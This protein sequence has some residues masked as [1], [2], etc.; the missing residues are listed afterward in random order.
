MLERIKNFGRGTICFFKTNKFSYKCPKCGHI[1]NISNKKKSKL[2][3][4]ECG[5]QGG[6]SNKDTEKNILDLLNLHKNKD[7]IYWLLHSDKKLKIIGIFLIFF[8]LIPLINSTTTNIKIAVTFLFLG[9]IAILINSGHSSN[10]SKMTVKK[11]GLL[12]SEKIT[13]TLFIITIALFFIT[14]GVGIE[15]F[16]ILLYLSLL[17]IKEF[18]DNNISIEIK[19]RLTIM[20]SV[21][22]IIFLIILIREITEIIEILK[23]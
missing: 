1:L 4:P 14:A 23:F 5:F 12:T 3:C 10:Y 7:K 21:M 9:L 19:K 22:F 18:I 16:I 15:V 2:T 20:T 8:S 11:E 6:I 13:L 17:I